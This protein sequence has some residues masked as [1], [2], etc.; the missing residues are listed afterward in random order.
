MG[1]G[2]RAGLRSPPSDAGFSTP[3]AS[4]VVPGGAP[5]LRSPPAALRRQPRVSRGFGLRRG[6]VRRGAVAP[7]GL[8]A[9]RFPTD[10]HRGPRAR[11]ALGRGCAPQPPHP[12]TDERSGGAAPA[13]RPSP[14][15]ERDH[16]PRVGHARSIGRRPARSGARF[17]A[18]QPHHRPLERAH[19][20]LG[21]GATRPGRP[22]SAYRGR[23]AGTKEHPHRRD[24]PRTPLARP[25]RRRSRGRH[26]GREHERHRRDLCRGVDVPPVA[27]AARPARGPGAPA[28]RGLCSLTPPWRW[29]R[30][31]S[32]AKPSA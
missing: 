14:R 23:V 15:S 21:D 20:L 12:G 27:R 18:R 28:P 25:R 11:S 32:S 6:H 10:G 16:S 24:R 30:A 3:R 26:R 22:L 31:E 5:V 13:L 17:L 19:G 8:A 1:W 9:A 29:N 4:F 7:C 2:A